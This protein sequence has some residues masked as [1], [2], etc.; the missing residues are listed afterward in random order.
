MLR[1]LSV[2]L[3][4]ML[5]ALNISA[6]NKK[7]TI[8]TSRGGIV[9][10]MAVPSLASGARCPVVLLMHGFSGTRDGK[11]EK[12]MAEKLL[13]VGIA[14]VRFDFDGHGESYGK[15]ED[16][17]VPLE[18]ED[19]RDVYEYVKALPWV[20]E[21][22]LCG[23][24]QGG[25]VASMLAGELE[26]PKV[27]AVVLF[28]PAAV[29]RDDC[30]RGSTM[31]ASYDPLDPPADGVPLFGGALTLGSEYI[32]TAFSLDIY[33]TAGKYKGPACILHGNADKV[34]PYS[35]GERYS[36]VWA[37][38]EYHLIDGEDHGFTKNLDG[39]AAIATEFLHRKLSKADSYS[40]ER[41]NLGAK[42]HFVPNPVVIIGTY[43]DDGT[44][45]AMLAAWVGQTGKNT[46]TLCLSPHRTTVNMLEKR[47]FTLSFVDADHVVE[48]DYLG[49]VSGTKVP[50]KVDRAG[51]HVARASNVNA[52]YF[53]EFP[54]TLEC[55]VVNFKDDGNGGLITGE[56]VN[57][58]ADPRILDEEGNLQI[59]KMRPLIYD[60]TNKDYHVVGDVVGKAFSIG[61]NIQ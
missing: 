8:Q 6:E 38:S 57:V 43:N 11:V 35:Y 12:A 50:D 5:I 44:P 14:S 21:V 16:M 42:M 32:R 40:D 30:I 52:P 10:D 61:H 48:A 18:I 31:G 54:L 9:A 26:Y 55:R 58:S 28:A 1:R 23:H 3:L 29:L 47:S 41:K 51:L 56:V 13:S 46:V 59:A 33:Q 37:G 60:D 24:S 19:A 15:F 27:S 22:A 7:I 25:V 36:L 49:S 53:K 20:S 39:A 2:I 45:N 17:T 34:V 4:S